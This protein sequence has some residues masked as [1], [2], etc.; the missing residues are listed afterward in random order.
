[1]ENTSKSKNIEE[2]FLIKNCSL[3]TISDS[4]QYLTL[5]LEP[6]CTGWTAKYSDWPSDSVVVLEETRNSHS[7]PRV[8]YRVRF[9]KLADEH[10]YVDGSKTQ[11]MDAIAIG[12]T[13]PNESTLDFIFIPANL[14]AVYSGPKE[15]RDYYLGIAD[16]IAA[17][18]TLR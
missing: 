5:I 3:Y 9:S 1:M 16:Q 10:F 13:P 6:I 11:L 12:Y 17:S 2:S 4:N 15:Q 7:G 14:K 8:N 18:I